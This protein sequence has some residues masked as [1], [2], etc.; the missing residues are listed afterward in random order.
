MSRQLGTDIATD[1]R[2]KVFIETIQEIC[3][4]LDI[5]VLGENVVSE[6]DFISIKALGIAGA[7]R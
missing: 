2:K 6:N 3:E 4:L 7:S 1:E 5:S